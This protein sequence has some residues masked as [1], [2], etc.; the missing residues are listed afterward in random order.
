VFDE[1]L[2]ILMNGVGVGFSV[3]RQFVNSL[4]LINEDF[5]PVE[6]SIQ[7]HDSRIGWA[8]AFRQVLALLYAGQIPRWDLSKLR[9]KGARLKT[10]GGRASGPEPLHAL[11][12]FAV[13]IFKKAAGR[14]L[15]S[16]EC[17]DLVCKIADTVIVGGVR[18]S[19]LI[20]L[21]NLSDDRMRNA[22]MGQWWIASPQRAL[23]NNSAAYTEKPDIE[24]FLKEWLSL[25]ESK[26]GERGI[27]NR[28]SATKKAASNGRRKT[29]GIQL[30]TNPCLHPDSLIETINGCI[31]IA[32]ITEPMMVYTMEDDGRLGIRQASA[33]WISKKNANTLIITISSGKKVRCTP[34]HKIFIEGRGWQ[35]ARNLTPGDRVVHLVRNR[36]GAAYSGVKLSTQSK[37]DFCME[38]RLVWSAVCGPIEEGYDIHHIDGDTY[39]NDIDNLECISHSDH[40]RLT[41]LEQPNNHQVRDR[42]GHFITHPKSRGGSKVVIPMPEEL[43]ANL[44]QYATIVSIELGEITDVYDISVEHTHNLIADFVVVHNC[45]EIY[46]RSRSASVISVKSSFVLKTLLIL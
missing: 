25:I 10:F 14:K 8:T 24:I 35:E 39:N 42:L 45:G 9:P 2:Y 41:A 26:C 36:R 40:S 11:F 31:R 38:H 18:R 34:D 4:P 32:D 46:L 33:S 13:E 20:S 3:E 28:V 16:V 12:T 22:K 7:V 6:T 15:N 43:K 21:S 27:F 1:I 17:H 29:E 37:Q 30:G 23:A 5:Y 44:H 19:A